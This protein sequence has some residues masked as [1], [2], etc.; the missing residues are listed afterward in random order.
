MM[1]S[2]QGYGLGETKGELRV[3]VLRIS[4]LGRLRH[5]WIELTERKARD[6]SVYN[7]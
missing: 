5:Q 4:L 2:R 3:V 6:S 7:L 1:K